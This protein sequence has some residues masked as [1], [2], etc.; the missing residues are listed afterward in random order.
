MCARVLDSRILAPRIAFQQLVAE[1]SA[2]KIL[3]MFRV[4][5]DAA[6]SIETDYSH[7]SRMAYIDKY[8]NKS[9]CQNIL[10]SICQLILTSICQLILTSICQ[11]IL[12][13]TWTRAPVKMS[14]FF[15]FFFSPFP[16]L[17]DLTDWLC[18]QWAE[19]NVRHLIITILILPKIAQNCHYITQN[20]YHIAQNCHHIAQN[21][22]LWA[23]NYQISSLPSFSLNLSSFSQLS[24]PTIEPNYIPQY[25]QY[26]YCQIIATVTTA[27][28]FLIIAFI[29]HTVL[30]YNNKL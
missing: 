7:N 25:Y 14:S 19:P 29:C 22:H 15:F 24:L 28:D 5:V 13:S 26:H 3:S 2:A 10:T 11:N 16:V 8:L 27:A 4:W 9:T 30:Y 23:H 1:F 20:S 18:C 17:H 21:Y 12:T 6:T